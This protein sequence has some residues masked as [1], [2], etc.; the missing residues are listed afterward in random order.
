MALDAATPFEIE[1]PA[2]EKIFVEKLADLQPESV[3]A[4]GIANMP[5]QRFNDFKLKAA[6]KTLA[7][8]KGSM[9]PT[10]SMYGGLGSRYNNRAS[11]ITGVTFFNDTIGKVIVG[12]TPYNVL[13]PFP[14][15]SSSKQGFFSQLNQNFNPC[16]L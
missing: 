12:G 13:A 3:Y 4:L 8:V 5:Q 15:Y 2:A 7:A 16:P 11:E 1:T 6:Q 10:I 9:Y 14:D